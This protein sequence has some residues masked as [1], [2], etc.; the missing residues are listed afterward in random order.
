MELEYAAHK[1]SLVFAYL[2]WL[3]F[4][5]FGAH[6]FYLGRRKTAFAMLAL[7][8]SPFVAGFLLGLLIGASWADVGDRLNTFQRITWAILAI[9]MLVD[10][11]L[12]PGM[13][14]GKN[15]ELV[16]SLHRQ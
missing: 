5:V 13:V 3:F 8:V 6:R 14:E 12:I 4:G 7:A 1:K 11:F 9:W 15:A 10:I 16:Q 2:A